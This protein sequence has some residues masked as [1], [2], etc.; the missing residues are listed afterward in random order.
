MPPLSPQGRQQAARMDRCDVILTSAC[1][2]PCTQRTVPIPKYA[3]L[4]PL[5]CCPYRDRVCAV[6]CCASAPHSKLEYVTGSCDARTY[7]HFCAALLLCTSGRALRI[8]SSSAG[9][10]YWKRPMV[11]VP[12]VRVRALRACRS[13]L[14]QGAK[15]RENIS[16]IIAQAGLLH[17]RTNGLVNRGC[18]QKDSN[19]QAAQS[20]RPRV[21]ILVRAY[22]AHHLL[23]HTRTHPGLP[24]A[25]DT[26]RAGPS[27][28]LCPSQTI[29][30]Q[31]QSRS[32]VRRCRADQ[33]SSVAA[34][35][36]ILRRPAVTTAKGTTTE[37]TQSRP[38]WLLL[39]PSS[40]FV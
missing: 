40:R 15:A 13:S 3:R 1:L 30:P 7:A 19:E 2:D 21:S 25:L 5:S 33:L 18:V 22:A 39:T 29:V 10:V 37:Y 14:L 38:F 23:T 34:W 12:A 32:K 27:V 31:F 16:Y 8:R 4:T 36:A 6:R 11:V 24:K 17:L 26:H 35:A 28:R 20:V 9:N